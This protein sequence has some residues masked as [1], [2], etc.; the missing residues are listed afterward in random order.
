MKAKILFVIVSTLMMCAW[1]N[2]TKQDFLYL[3]PA[4][5]KMIGININENGVFYKNTNPEWQK[6]NKR[7]SCLSFYCGNDM[8]LSTQHYKETDKLKADK[9]EERILLKMPPT[10]NDFYPLLIGNIHGEQS[11]DDKSLPD[12]Y[13]MLPV[14]ICM[15][16]TNLPNRNDTIVVWFKPTEML[17]KAMPTGINMED[18]LKAPVALDKY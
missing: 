4:Q 18:Y 2:T 7:Y 9:K 10:K 3:T 5:L 16:Y 6:D 15:S 13:K 12:D 8:Y 17:Q 1:T 14:A 11:L